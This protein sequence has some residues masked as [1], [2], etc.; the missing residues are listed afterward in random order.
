MAGPHLG[1]GNGP[2]RLDLP[3]DLLSRLSI[4]RHLCHQQGFVKQAVVRGLG[5]TKDRPP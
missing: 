5:R 4:G 3:G 2:Y 1:M